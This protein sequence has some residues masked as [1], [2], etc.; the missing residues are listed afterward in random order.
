MGALRSKEHEGTR[1][2]NGGKSVLNN[3]GVRDI[4]K[5]KWKD[6]PLWEARPTCHSWQKNTAPFSLT[7]LVMGFQASICSCV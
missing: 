7:A 3:T 1:D 4:G 2:A 6:V 5:L